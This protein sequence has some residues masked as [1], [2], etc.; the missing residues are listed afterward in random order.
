MRILY[1]LKNESHKKKVRWFL[2]LTPTQ[3]YI[4]M[5]EI[6]SFAKL[7]HKPIKQNDKKPFKTIQILKRP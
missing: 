1:G 2:S 4:R 6:A 5:L 7:H 3:R